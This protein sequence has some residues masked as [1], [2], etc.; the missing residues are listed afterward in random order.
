VFA[1]RYRLATVLLWLVQGCSL[2][3]VF[4]M[5]T[6]PPTMMKEIGYSLGAALA[7]ALI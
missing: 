6:W 5:V 3:L 7:F 2:F 1:P 4:G